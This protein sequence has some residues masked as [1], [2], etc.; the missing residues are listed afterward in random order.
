MAYDKEGER[1]ENR[2]NMMVFVF[3]CY[4]RILETG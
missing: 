1:L 4:D 3:C 2:E